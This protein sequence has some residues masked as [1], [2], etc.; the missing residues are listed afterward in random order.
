VGGT[1]AREFGDLTQ[2]ATA[3]LAARFHDPVSVGIG[4]VFAL[5]AV[6]ALAIAG[7]RALLKIIPLTW[8]T[9]IAA[10]IMLVLAGISLAAAVS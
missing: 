6:A 7:G 4:A 10:A 8:I 9:R 3:S 2:I 5:W 1:L